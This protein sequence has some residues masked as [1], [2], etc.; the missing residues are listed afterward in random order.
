MS[1]NIYYYVLNYE[2]ELT[3]TDQKIK[4]YIINNWNNKLIGKEIASTL[5]ISQS[6]VSKFIAK[7]KFKSIHELNL[8]KNCTDKEIILYLTDKRSEILSDLIRLNKHE[9]FEGILDSLNSSELILT[10]GIGHSYL[11]AKNFKQ[12]FSKL[13]YNILLLKER[14]DVTLN[15]NNIF[16]SSS[17]ALI[18]SDSATTEEIVVFSNFCLKNNIKYT[19]TTSNLF[20][21]LNNY[22]EYTL[23]YKPLNIGYLLETIGPEQPIISLIDLLYLRAISSDYENKYNDFMISEYIL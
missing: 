18:F 17:Y 23:T 22:S 3:K 14:Y 12:R 19:L 6:S 13:G 20:S 8:L 10:Y 9:V 16:N 15:I 21:K 1:D 5:C 7:L 2:T 4:N 11:C